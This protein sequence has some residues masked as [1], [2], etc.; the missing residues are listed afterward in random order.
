MYV[1]TGENK[2]IITWETIMYMYVITG[3]NKVPY[4]I[5]R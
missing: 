2:Y 5:T 3:E 1:I 4:I